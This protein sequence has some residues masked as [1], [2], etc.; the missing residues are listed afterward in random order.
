LHAIGGLPLQRGED[1]AAVSKGQGEIGW[2]YC[3]AGIVSLM[4]ELQFAVE[5]VPPGSGSGFQVLIFV[6]GVEVTAAGAGLG[7]DPY[8]VLVPEN[9]F[10]PRAEPHTVGVAR[11]GCG[12]YGCGATDVTITAAREA[13]TWSWSLEAP[14]DHPVSFA[15]DRYLSE[16]NRIA[17][18]HS[19]ETPERTAGRLVLS[20]INRPNLKLKGL[21]P[22]WLGN[23]WRAPE[24]FEVCLAFDASYQ[25]FLRFPWN[26]DSPEALAGRVLATLND[27][28]AP[29]GWTATWHGIAA[30]DR[31]RPPRIAQAGWTKES[32]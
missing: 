30:V 17:S 26:G 9:K 13:V 31:L 16:A 21:Q 18:D 6:D 2:R 28:E 14:M 27:P 12:E 15:L 10:L 19:W 22:S 1:M 32:I 4:E 8:D 29:L 3:L 23:D 11:C 5:P 24:L 25:I 7:M 20:R